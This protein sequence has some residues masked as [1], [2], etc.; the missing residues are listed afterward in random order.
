[1]ARK[2]KT[3]YPSISKALEHGRVVNY[4]YGVNTFG[5][6]RVSLNIR[7]FSPVVCKNGWSITAEWYE[8]SEVYFNWFVRWHRNF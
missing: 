2:I 4:Y 6:S 3:C 7:Y 8:C 1:M 5:K